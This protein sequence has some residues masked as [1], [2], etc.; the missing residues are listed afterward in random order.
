MRCRRLRGGRVSE[1]FGL[2]L[3]DAQQSAERENQDL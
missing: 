2:H 3:S 1:L